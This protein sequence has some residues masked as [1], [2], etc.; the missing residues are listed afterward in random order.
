MTD[1]EALVDAA[2]NALLAAHHGHAAPD[3]AV[4]TGE[5][6]VVATRLTAGAG[7]DVNRPTAR[8]TAQMPGR[9][10]A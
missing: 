8:A 1:P 4:S 3:E 6:E 5:G 10:L 7:L 9:D 2:D